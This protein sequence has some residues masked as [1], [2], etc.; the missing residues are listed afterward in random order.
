M[1]HRPDPE[2]PEDNIVYCKSMPV[3]RPFY[4]LGAVYGM[5]AR[6]VRGYHLAIWFASGI[7]IALSLTA[8]EKEYPEEQTPAPELSVAR[9]TTTTTEFAAIFSWN[10]D[11]EVS[12]CG[13]VWGENENPTLESNDGATIDNAGTGSFTGRIGDLV[14]GRTYF[15]RAYIIIENDTIYSEQIK[16][17]PTGLPEVIT[18]DVSRI[19]STSAVSGAILKSDDGAPVS[20]L[21]IVWG[22]DE[23][24]TVDRNEGKITNGNGT[25]EFTTLIRGLSGETMYYVRAFATNEAG[26]AYGNQVSFITNVL[27]ADIDGNVYKTVIIGEQEW[28]TENLRVSRYSN[29]DPIPADPTDPEW[30]KSGEARLGSQTVYQHEE[31]QGLYSKDEVL[32]AYGALY[33][34]YAVNDERGLCPTGW[35]VPDNDDWKDLV[36]YLGGPETAGGKLKSTAT[37]PAS[38]P[39]WDNPNT[40]ATN[41]SGFTALPGG[42]RT[43]EGNFGLAGYHGYWWSAT[44]INFFGAG[45]ITIGSRHGNVISSI[46]NRM[47]SFSVRCLREKK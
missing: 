32:D 47:N 8:C 34:W 11:G 44:E 24:P 12:V 37:A 1:L 45:D 18:R 26:T 20:D 46:G 19:T 9:V 28:M 3:L 40:D 31:L 16:F 41:E 29:G 23:N 5:F 42:S 33:N 6:M 36:D 13:I 39:R 10:M 7:L 35:R 17:T 14:P 25:G 21:G 15:F 4:Q 27:A 2:P 43:S 38:H 30:Q 22:K